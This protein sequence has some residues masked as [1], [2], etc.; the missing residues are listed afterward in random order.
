MKSNK[1]MQSKIYR[2]LDYVL[3]LILLN[4][5]S[6]IPSFSFFI[7]YV[8]LNKNS[9]NPFIYLSLIPVILWLFPSIVSISS[10]I[11]QY[12]TK[13]TNTIFK[14]FFKS[15]KNTY[16]KSLLFTLII[17]VFG[18]ILYNSLMYFSNY[19]RNSL[20]N[21]VGL[22]LTISCIFLFLIVIINI[23]LVMSYFKGLRMIEIVK[24]S[25]IMA[26]KDLLSNILSVIIFLIFIILDT[27]FYVL[28]AFGGISV[29]IYLVIKLTFKKY[30]KIYRKVEEK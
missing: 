29:P 25:C 12:E 3:R 13:D 9:D 18:F 28:M 27:L 10:V 24:L 15:L 19:V 17:I 14:D 4:A 30:I 22:I 5:L 6:I 2:F 21:F 7:I 11:R 16:L 8:L 23:I 26:F 20:I 1:I